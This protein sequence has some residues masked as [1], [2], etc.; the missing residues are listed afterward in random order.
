[1]ADVA[2]LEWAC[3][4][5]Y[6]EA[7]PVPLAP[8]RLADV[9]PVQQMRLRLHLAPAVRFV[10]SRYP[11]L[12]IWQSHQ[13]DTA[14]AGSPISLDEGGVRL[15]VARRALDIEFRRLGD[16]EDLWLRALAAGV[17]LCKAT[18]SALAF[19]P[20]FDLA[21][22]LGRHLSLGS[23]SGLSLA[24]HDAETEMRRP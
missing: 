17:T 21:N 11:V 16:A 18:A 2:A 8:A 7:D 1:M 4:E 15:L 5:V 23:F 10:A 24:S 14:D 6:H 12:R 19:D 3:H 9:S 13:S 20:A 22:A